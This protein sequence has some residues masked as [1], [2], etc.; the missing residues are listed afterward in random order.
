MMRYRGQK[1][2]RRLKNCLNNKKKR[3]FRE[4]LIKNAQADTLGIWKVPKDHMKASVPV[5]IFII[6][7]K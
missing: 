4:S 5:R 3:D 1:G 7:Q 6:I 2:N